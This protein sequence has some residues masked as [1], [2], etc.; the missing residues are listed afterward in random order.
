M[1]MSIIW[2]KCDS[3]SGIL[4]KPIFYRIS[5][6]M[7][8]VVLSCFILAS[9]FFSFRLYFVWVCSVLYVVAALR[10]NK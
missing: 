10:R 4:C 8:Y 7:S 2:P 6:F 3:L 5:V 9:C 1:D